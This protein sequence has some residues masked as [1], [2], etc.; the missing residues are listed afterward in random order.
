[1]PCRADA[2]I[3]AITAANS[4]GGGTLRLTPGCRYALTQP[5]PDTDSGL[6]PIAA[7][8]TINGNGATIT[9]STAATTPDFRILEI[10]GAPA[11]LTIRL[12]T[13]S[14]GISIGDQVPGGGHSGG[15]ILVREGG[16]L[17]AAVI[18][19]TGNSGSVGGIHN[20]GTA[21]LTDSGVTG[22]TGA[23]GG[24]LN[25]TGG[26]LSLVRTLIR[27]NVTQSDI[28]MG[29]GIYNSQGGTT[30]VTGSV[31]SRNLGIDNG[32]GIHN[33]GNLGVSDSW[34]TQNRAASLFGVPVVVQGG[35][36]Y[37]AG[38]ARILRSLVSGNHS[39]RQQSPTAT[40]AIAGGI[41]NDGTENPDV[42]TTL[43]RS[44]VVGNTAV[45]QPG[46]I[47]NAAGAFNLDDSLVVL[48][49]PT[50]CAGSPDPVPH[51]S[52]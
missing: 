13:I 18:T 30:T 24:G 7:P 51:C 27:D 45:D 3:E 41:S 40:T 4:A 37:N 9:R 25:N 38:T 43:E 35:G 22:N 44:L 6:P 12:T 46:G 17:A 36:I 15:G 11:K 23:W 1:M 32:G 26:T 5:R 50:N 33:E 29:G 10:L 48:N 16:A 34:I 28:G 31:I 2:L 42:V 21:Q 39:Q 52:G 49:T 19:V 47:S 14:N 8:I 20:Y